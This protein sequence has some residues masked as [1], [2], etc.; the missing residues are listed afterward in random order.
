MLFS[1]QQ[2]SCIRSHKKLFESLSFEL[3]PGQ[4]LLVE[5]KNGAGKTSLLK[6]L[7]GLRS[8]D[9]GE[10]LWNGQNI[11]Q[12]NETF[13]SELAWLG[14]QNPLKD[15]QTA[16]ENLMLLGQIRPR[17]QTSY[18]EALTTLNLN[19]VKHKRVKTFSA[20][21]KRRLSLASLLITEASLWILDEPQASLD[22]AGIKL[23]ESLAEKH[24]QRGGMVIMTSHH[25]VNINPNV[26]KTLQLGANA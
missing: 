12:F 6:M 22:K 21:M 15:E 23:F 11:I 3:S 17:N 14:H 20:G 16:L 1:A 13:S 4:L 5:G 18:I 24:L 8:P 25:A 9:Q 26:I 10:I 2:L 19:H 7:I